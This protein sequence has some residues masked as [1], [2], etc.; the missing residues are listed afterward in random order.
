M[1]QIHDGNCD[2]NNDD[3][4]VDTNLSNSFVGEGDSEY[5]CRFAER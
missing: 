1:L 5:P 4:D 2:R 3:D